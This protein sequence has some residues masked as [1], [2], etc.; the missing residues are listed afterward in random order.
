[1]KSVKMNS[2][3]KCGMKLLDKD[4]NH[5]TKSI[6]IAPIHCILYTKG[7]EFLDTVTIVHVIAYKVFKLNLSFILRRT[8]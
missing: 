8:F 6:L 5:F 2:D 3:I 1:M 4:I 7:Y